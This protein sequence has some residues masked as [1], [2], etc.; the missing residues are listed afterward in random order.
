MTK[1]TRYSNSKSTIVDDDS[2][3]PTHV[4]PHDD[5]MDDGDC[6]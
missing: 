3:Q 5:I 1:A 6:E 4:C 2:A